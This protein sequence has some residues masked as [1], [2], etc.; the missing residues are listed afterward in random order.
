MLNLEEYEIAKLFF[1][2]FNTYAS[3]LHS[4]LEKR[5]AGK[6]F[7]DDKNNPSFVLVCSSS[8]LSNLNA[9]AYLGGEI[10]QVSL[11]KVA[12]YLKTLPKVSLVALSNWEFRTFF[13]EEG[14]TAIPAAS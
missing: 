7:T 12:S 8:V 14:F 3:I 10:D 4:I 11:R 2:D 1:N 13:E 9:P 5:S 6:V